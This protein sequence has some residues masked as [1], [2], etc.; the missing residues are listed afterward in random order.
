MQRPSKKQRVMAMTACEKAGGCLGAEGLKA[1]NS[2]LI[3]R[4]INECLS[5]EI[6]AAEVYAAAI[7]KAAGDGDA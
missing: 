4:Y 6:L 3:K 5:A 7:K 1:M 2:L